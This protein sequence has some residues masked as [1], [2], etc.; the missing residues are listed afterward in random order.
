MCPQ[1]APTT[2]TE[3]FL[4]MFDYIDRLFCNVRPRKLLFMAIGA[5]WTMCC[6]VLIIPHKITASGWSCT[7]KLSIPE[8]RYLIPEQ[9]EV[10]RTRAPRFFTH[11]DAVRLCWS[12]CPLK[13]SRRGARCLP[14]VSVCRMIIPGAICT[15]YPKSHVPSAES[16]WRSIPIL[17]RSSF[18]L[19]T[20][21]HV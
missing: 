12:V 17:P 13:T 7:G 9:S 15:F 6:G 19:L 20:H 16:R 10:H 11:R 21:G 1:P 8:Q 2:E 18:R 3:V 4:C 5:P 14:Q